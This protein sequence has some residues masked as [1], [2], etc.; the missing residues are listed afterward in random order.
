MS[1][2]FDP[3]LLNRNWDTGVIAYPDPAIEVIDPA[4][5]NT[6]LTTPPLNGSVPV[7]AGQKGQSGLAM[8][9]TYFGATSQITVVMR[10]DGQNRRSERLPYAFQQQQRPHAD[11][12]GRLISCEHDARA[13]YP[14]RAR[15]HHY[16]AHGQ[17]RGE[18]AQRANDVA[19]HADGSI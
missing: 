12:Q 13:C 4:L 18:T 5:P 9:A 6:I 7:C 1:R 16:G 14:H 11:R 3:Y 8:G 2:E 10:W 15:W 17:L 19:V